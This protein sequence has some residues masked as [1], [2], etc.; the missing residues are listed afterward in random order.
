MALEDLAMMRPLFNTTVLYPSDAVSAE[1]LVFEAAQTDGIVYIRTG[2]PKT[3]V[4]YDNKEAFPI[5]GSKILRSSAKDSAVVVAAGVTLYEALKAYDALKAEGLLVRVIDAYSIKPLDEVTMVRA[6]AE[7]KF[8]VTVEDHSAF[9]GLGDAVCQ[10]VAGRA[11]VKVLAVRRV[12]QSG[13]PA[14]LMAVCGIDAKAIVAAVKSR[15]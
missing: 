12:P 5:G 2:R 7:T 10:A 6:A 1:K 15:L 11:P 14:E 13:T 8:V 9:G 3:K 4:I